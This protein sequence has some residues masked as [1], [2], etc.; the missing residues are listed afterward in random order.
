[1][2][3]KTHLW[4]LLTRTTNGGDGLIPVFGSAADSTIA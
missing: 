3:G 2:A 4:I 1:M